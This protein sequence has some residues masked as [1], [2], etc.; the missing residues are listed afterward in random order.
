MNHEEKGGEKKINDYATV[1]GICDGVPIFSFNHLTYVYGQ[2]PDFY[3]GVDMQAGN[4]KPSMKIKLK[5]GWEIRNNFVGVCHE[6][7]PRTAWNDSQPHRPLH[8]IDGDPDTIWSSFECHVPDGRPEWIRIDLPVESVIS[9]VALTCKK[10]YMGKDKGGFYRPQWNFGNA[11]PKALAVKISRDAWNWETVFESKDIFNQFAGSNG[12]LEGCPEDPDAVVITLP[13]PIPAKQILIIANNFMKIG[14]EGYMF[15]ING[16]QIRDER[17]NNLALFSR[18]A[19]VTV[20]SVSNHH[21]TDLYAAKSL[22]GPLQY[23]LGNKW[24]KIGSDNGSG[25]WCFTEHEKGDLEVDIEFDKAVTEAVN[26]G[27]HIIL[28]LDFKG[29]WIYENPPR[30][31]NW[32]SARFHEINESYMCG[33]PLA[34]DSPEMFEGY[35]KY[36][37]YMV[38]HFQDRV[39]YFEI[40]N[41]W[42]IWD[43]R[44]TLDWY[45]D[46]IFSPTYDMIKR[47]LP[48]AKILLGSPGGFLPEVLLDCL[49]RLGY[50]L[51]GPLKRRVDAVGWHTGEPPD[52]NYF[53]GVRQFKRCCEKLGFTGAYFCNEVYAGSVYPPGPL[54]N[55]DIFRLS[56]LQEA[57]FLLR[58]IVGHSSLNVE[59]GNCHV[60][61]TGFPHPQ[62][63]CRTTWPNQVTAPCQPKPSYYC[64][65]NAA[66]VLDDFYEADFPVIF[67]NNANI[68]H[69]SLISGDKKL[70]MLTIWVQTPLLDILTEINTDILLPGNPCV[71]AWA[72]DLFNGMEQELELGVINGNTVIKGILIKDY[73]VCLKLVPEKSMLFPNRD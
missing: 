56:D 54:N 15:S 33:I 14:Y 20:S 59:A 60:F 2:S 37:E 31:T 67:S 51:G 66:T 58:S 16:I 57:K 45:M 6:M 29:N 39:D 62:A 64:L 13:K 28:T 26:N 41:E 70:W 68:I 49:K 27:I 63:L 17:G 30:K 73:P 42:N 1:E 22:W 9:S 65:R 53:N 11:L 35:L 52:W 43:G 18:G 24:V 36:V 21:G 4:L 10:N 69:F 72:V 48:D 34:D 71:K 44:R 47:I 55:G 25:L 3:P 61:F 12:I 7:T 23:D 40:G 38:K 8:L 50:T 5:K 19:G 32:F 46:T